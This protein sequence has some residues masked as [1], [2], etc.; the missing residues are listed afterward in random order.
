MEAFLKPK[1]ASFLGFEGNKV[2]MDSGI[3]EVRISIFL[4]GIGKIGGLF[5]R[6]LAPRTVEALIR[7]LPITGRVALLKGALYVP[8]SSKPGLGVEKGITLAK[9]G[10]IGYWP[11]VNALCLFYEDMKMRTPL[12]PV[13]RILDDP[14]ILKSVPSGTRIVV[15]MWPQT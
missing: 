7:M 10:F 5:Q 1:G 9:K 14:G 15:A 11:F 8:I 4:E 6:F 12:S 2:L 3:T 13:G